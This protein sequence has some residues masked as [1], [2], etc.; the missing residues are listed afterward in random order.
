MGLG[1]LANGLAYWGFLVISV[2]LGVGLGLFM[3]PNNTVILAILPPAHRGFA[4]GML[5]TSRQLGH[6]LGVSASSA[7]LGLVVVT[8]LPI[9]GERAAYMQG[10]QMP[11][12]TAGAITFVGMILAIISS[13]A[14][15]RREGLDLA[16][17]AQ[18][19]R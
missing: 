9:M 12:F 2:I 18:S 14:P 19:S 8:S 3:T 6:T 15:A 7:V 17:A 16:P 11:T 5:E 4:V 13:R 1:L 10:F